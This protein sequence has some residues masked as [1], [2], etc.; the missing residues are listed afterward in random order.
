MV[1]DRALKY[2]TIEELEGSLS[3]DELAL[4]FDVIAMLKQKSLLSEGRHL[5]A[6]LELRQGLEKEPHNVFLQLEFE[7]CLQLCHQY[8]QSLL[9]EDTRDPSIE[10]MYLLLKS[11]SSIGTETESLYVKY[12][13]ACKRPKEALECIRP[14][15]RTFPAQRGLRP[16]VETMVQHIQHPEL[17][18][19]LRTPTPEPEIECIRMPHSATETREL[20]QQFK[21]ALRALESQADISAAQKIV[22]DTIGDWPKNPI[23][24]PV[25]KD[26]YYL[27][28]R[29]ESQL[30]RPLEAVYCLQLYVKM[31]AANIYARN[32]LDK[33]LQDAFGMILNYVRKGEFLDNLCE[34]YECYSRYAPVPYTLITEVAKQYIR[35]GQRERGRHL[36]N[37]LLCESRRQRLPYCEP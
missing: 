9:L 1:R 26:F 12:L 24:D 28:A 23:M 16:I 7:G 21:R 34:F 10:P 11:E 33:C 19:Y 29:I 15:V 32:F 22:K 5:Q 25:L 31:D 4:S 13:L 2:S 14:L 36:M 17:Q 30:E 6:A 35:S 3:P 37:N 27:K 18:D 8:L 20:T